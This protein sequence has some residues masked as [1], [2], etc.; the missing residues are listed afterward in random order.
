MQRRELLTRFF[1]NEAQKGFI[2]LAPYNKEHSLFSK[3]CTTCA[4][5]NPKPPCI[6]ACDEVYNKEN[7]G[8][9]RFLDGVVSVDFSVYGCKI[10]GKCAKSC[11]HSVLDKELAQAQN[12]HWNFFVKISEMECLAHQKVM[13]NVC[14]DICY[15]VLGKDN[16]ISFVG[17]FYPQIQE[18]CI[19]C[20][21]C[22]RGC[23]TDAIVLLER[24][25]T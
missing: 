22:L 5:E 14:K 4:S 21:E 24:E 13:C 3:F 12:P 15:S 8:I 9:L 23:P 2:P 11:P 1:K 19:G 25:R 18:S 17:L 6:V 16:A 20:G 7:A 10:C